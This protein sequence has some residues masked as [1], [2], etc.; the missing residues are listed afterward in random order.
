MPAP[1]TRPQIG[2]EPTATA[3]PAIPATLAR[4]A[5]NA[6]PDCIAGIDIIPSPRHPRHRPA[7]S[8]HSSAHVASCVNPDQPPTPAA[9]TWF[10]AIASPAAAA[11]PASISPAIHLNSRASRAGVRIDLVRAAIVVSLSSSK[12]C[13][14]SSPSASAASSRIIDGSVANAT[15]S[16]ATALQCLDAFPLLERS[17]QTRGLPSRRYTR[18]V[19]DGTGGSDARSRCCSEG[20]IIPR[21]TLP[22]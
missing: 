2:V 16:T 3:N 17:L 14:A 8:P 6:C 10:T 15:A 7:P 4:T 21:G 5:S 9:R 13:F 20:A 22:G 12:A 1:R 19:A 18:N 11:T